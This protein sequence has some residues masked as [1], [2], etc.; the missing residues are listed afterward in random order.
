[1]GTNSPIGKKVYLLEDL[2][3]ELV[4]LKEQGK[5]IV[6][7]HGVF[8]LMH[9]GIVQHLNSAK[10]QGDILVVT[11][12]KDKDVR[13]GPGRPIFS[14]DFR[15]ESVASFSQVDYACVVDD[16]QPFECVNRIKPDIF[17][18]GQAYKERDRQIHNKIFEEEK[19]FYFGQT[20]IAETDGFTISSSQL[21]QQ[22]IN[23]L[24]EE[25]RGY[26]K[27]I[28][29][30]F[31][32]QEILEKIHQLSSQKV[33]VIGDGIVDEYHYCEPM[34]KAGK[35]NLVVNKYLGH[36]VFAGGAFAIANHVASV[37]GQVDIVS[38]LGEVDSREEF[39]KESLKPNVG[40]KF[41]MR[42]D[43]P[44]VV[45]KRY[46]HQYLNQK[47]FEVN[48]INDAFI[49]GALETEI[50]NYL[51]EVLPKYDSVLLSDFG[52]GFI[53]SNIYSAIEKHSRFLAIN[54]QTNA[55]NSGYN[56][57]TK[58]KNP[59]FVCLDE[60]EIRLA[61]QEKYGSVDDIAQ[62]IRD[63]VNAENLIVTLGKKGSLGVSG[64][65]ETCRTPIFS[66]K[67]VDTIGAGDAFFA[68]AAP[69]V[70]SGMPMDLVS[71]VGNVVGAL[72]VQIMG[73]KRSVERFE[74]L[75]L[76]HTLSK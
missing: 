45:K 38:L 5:V 68:Y 40:S 55:A 57:I 65:N 1:M 72:A 18:K 16:E 28:F 29:I 10:K 14:Q 69:A 24:P 59:D 61:A 67:V 20:K 27:R 33:L 74:V 62:N 11:V 49:D 48:F 31:P 60:A 46:L 22:F 12:I 15:V 56:M 37:C 17:A 66:T 7:T 32:Y 52:H 70:A 25:T 34:G 44:T 73:N 30:K 50:I 9:P 43:G 47:L 58:Y 41:F 64:E 53:N 39:V 71:F 35:A 76:I 4:K 13:R 42:A 51:S 2:I 54:T 23:L 8:D 19:D 75:E 3:A 6:Q 21:L 36:E 63:Q 26:L